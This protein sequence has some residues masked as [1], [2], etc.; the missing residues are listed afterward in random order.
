MKKNELI[1]RLEE[2]GGEIKSDKLAALIEQA[3]PQSTDDGTRLHHYVVVAD[4]K[5]N[6]LVKYPKQMVVVHDILVA[7]AGVG[8]RITRKDARVLI[9]AGVA[10]G[11]L[12]TRQDPDRIYAFYQK[13]M[14]D[15]GW[16]TREKIREA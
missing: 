9:E 6:P 5:M 10:D 8:T 14:E 11:R 3:R 15:E 16:L 13:R 4:R 1:C 12:Q 2:L 7:D